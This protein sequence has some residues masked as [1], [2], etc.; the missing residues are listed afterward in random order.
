MK[1]EKV[2]AVKLGDNNLLG[3]NTWLGDRAT[4]DD[5]NDL[6]LEPLSAMI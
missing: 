4:N 2:T 3:W 5:A 1:K 6:L